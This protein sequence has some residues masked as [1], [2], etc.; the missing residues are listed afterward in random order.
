[1]RARGD[2]LG[3]DGGVSVHHIAMSSRWVRYRDLV[4]AGWGSA[5]FLVRGLWGRLIGSRWSWQGGS[6]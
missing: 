1:M 4:I 5:A 6:C 2:R 3:L